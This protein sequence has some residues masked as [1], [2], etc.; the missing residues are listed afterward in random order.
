MWGVDLLG[1]VGVLQF[2]QLALHF[3]SAMLCRVGDINTHGTKH[4]LCKSIMHLIFALM[5]PELTAIV[6]G[7]VNGIK[8]D[9]DVALAYM[10]LRPNSPM[11]DSSAE[12]W[13]QEP[14][15]VP[16]KALKAPLPGT[17]LGGSPR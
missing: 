14:P 2:T 6:M 8:V 7:A 13:T 16:E 12:H 1:K 17:P 15:P 5:D 10:G 9:R 4:P 3:A 11:S